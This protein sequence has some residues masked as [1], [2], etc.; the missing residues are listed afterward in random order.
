LLLAASS[1]G[2][3]LVSQ[4]QPP[5]LGTE[6]VAVLRSDDSTSSVMDRRC[7]ALLVR[8]YGALLDWLKVLDLDRFLVRRSTLCPRYVDSICQKL[9]IDK[10]MNGEWQRPGSALVRRWFSAGENSH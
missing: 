6:F 3:F 5:Y 8:R 1:P 9:D 2:L 7:G 4:N 10:G